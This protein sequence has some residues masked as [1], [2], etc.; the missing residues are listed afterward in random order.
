MEKNDLIR[1]KHMLDASLEAAANVS[2]DF[3]EKYPEIPWQKIVG[4][5]NRLIHAYFNVNP[6]IVW[7][8]VTVEVPKIIP[9]LQSLV[10]DSEN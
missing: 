5:R 3:R 2:F 6:E 7:T 1:I 9:F 8:A 10:D 4:M